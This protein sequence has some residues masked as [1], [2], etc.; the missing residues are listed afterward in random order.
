MSRYQILDTKT[1]EV[2]PIIHSRALW[3]VEDARRGRP[4]SYRRR[5]G[6]KQ[7]NAMTELLTLAVISVFV[8]VLVFSI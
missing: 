5:T 2:T 3:G 1:G 4:S 7:H 6:R 8:A